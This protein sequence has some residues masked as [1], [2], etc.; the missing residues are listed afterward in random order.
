MRMEDLKQ[1]K[2][3][4]LWRERL[5]EADDLFSD[6]NI[7]PSELALDAF[8]DSLAALGEAPPEDGILA[9]VRDIVQAF[10]E[11]NDEH[12]YFI[13]TMEREELCTFIAGA[14][15]RAGLKVPEGIDITKEWREW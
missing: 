7:I 12:G 5:A 13:D 10:N 2:P 8:I 6:E 4:R 15:Q 9:Q 1:N 3:T 11:L 14:A